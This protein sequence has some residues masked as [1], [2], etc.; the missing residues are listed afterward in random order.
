MLVPLMGSD[1]G[2]GSSGGSAC[3]ATSSA[4]SAVEQV[5]LHAAL[6][7]QGVIDAVLAEAAG[8]AGHEAAHVEEHHGFWSAH[9]IAMALSIVLALGGIALGLVVYYERRD[10]TTIVSAAKLKRYLLPIWTLLWNKYYFDEMYNVAVVGT[11]KIV[12]VICAFFDRQVIDRIVGLA[13]TVTRGL[14]LVVDRLDRKVVDGTVNGSA[15][16]SGYIGGRLAFSQTGRVRQYLLFM[17]L[18]MLAVAFA[19]LWIA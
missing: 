2:A 6:G 5:S 13:A 1:A 9:N 7:T 10:G 4:A 15:W 8:A 19:I 18:G 14:S 17:V 11:F 3:S 16:S 12:A